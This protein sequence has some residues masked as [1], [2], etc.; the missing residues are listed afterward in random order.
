MHSG[1]FYMKQ[2]LW[3][4]N[5]IALQSI[6]GVQQMICQKLICGESFVISL[7]LFV[8][9]PDGRHYTCRVYQNGEVTNEFGVGGEE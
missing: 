1:A 7:V 2:G 3:E 6:N 5:H 8:N 4:I 9:L